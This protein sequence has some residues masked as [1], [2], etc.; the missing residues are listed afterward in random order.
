M[1]ILFLA[2]SSSAQANCK[3]GNRALGTPNHLAGAGF[4]PRAHDPVAL[5][6]LVENSKSPIAAYLL[7]FTPSHPN[8]RAVLRK[9]TQHSDPL[10]VFLALEALCRQ[11]ESD[12]L[13]LGPTK[14]RTLTSD[15]S[16]AARIAAARLAGL[17][18]TN[19]IYEGWPYIRDTLLK[20][21]VRSV[22]FHDSLYGLSGFPRKWTTQL[23]NA[24]PDRKTLIQPY[25]PKPRKPAR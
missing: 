11:G 20:S 15:P 10:L 3:M 12:L 17:L 6:E 18:A 22:E 8:S 24:S 25:L 1:L 14:L 9:A 7:G 16:M 4:G 5:R 2:A 13:T 19:G 21:D 23:A